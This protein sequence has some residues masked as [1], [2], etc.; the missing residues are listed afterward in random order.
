[1]KQEK[2]QSIYKYNLKKNKEKGSIT[3]YVLVACIFFTIVLGL[4]YVNLVYKSQGVEENLEQ[5]QDNYSKNE[6]EED[7]ANQDM[8]VTIQYKDPDI[9]NTWVKEITLVGS[10]ERK[11]GT[12]RNIA[13]YAFAEYDVDI[14]DIVW[15]ETADDEK[16]NLTKEVTIK[17]NGI[18]R[19][20]VKNDNE[21]ISYSD[22]LTVAN[23]DNIN[24]TPGY[25]EAT[26]IDPSDNITEFGSYNFGKWTSYNVYIE[27]F[28]GTDDESGH[29]SSKMTILKNSLT[30]P[31]WQNIDG[32][33]TLTEIG[34]YT[35]TVT[36]EDNLGNVSKSE[37]YYV[38]IDKNVPTLILKYHDENGGDYH[39]EWTNQDLYG[40]L[41]INTSESGKTVQ[42]YQYSQNGYTWNDMMDLSG[43]DFVAFINEML[44]NVHNITTDYYFEFNE[45]KTMMGSNNTNVNNSISEGYM[46]LDL[47]GYPW[48]N[49][50]LSISAKVS[51]EENHDYGFMEITESEES[52]NFDPNND[53]WIKVSGEQEISEYKLLS[54]GKKYYLHYGYSKDESTSVGTDSFS[55]QPLIVPAYFIYFA[56]YNKQGNNVTF[57]FTIESY[58]DDLYFRAIYD[59][60]T[61][62]YSKKSSSYPMRIDKTAPVV[63]TELIANGDKVDVKVNATDALSGIKQIYLSTENV[64][65]T[66]DSEW[67]SQTLSEFELN[68]LEMDTVYYLWV[69][70][71]AGNISEV[72]TFQTQANYRIDGDK[73]TTTLQQA[74]QV[75]STESISTIELLTGYDDKSEVVIDRNIVLDLK[76]FVLTRENEITINEGVTVR[77]TGKENS[78][79]TTN[80]SNTNTIIN[81]GNLMI[82]GNAV[83]ENFS[84]TESNRTI[85]NDGENAVI[86][87][88]EEAW[89]RGYYY[90]IYN[91]SGTVVID[92]GRV[93]STYSASSARGI[94]NETE[95]SKLYINNGEVQGYYGIYNNDVNSL[96]EITGGKVVGLNADGIHNIGIVNLYGGRVEGKSFG[97]YSESSNTVTI[98]RETDALTNTNPA[99]YGE[100][101]AVRMSD[102]T[103]Q[104]NLYNGTIGSTSKDTNYNGILNPRK[105]YMPYTYLST[106]DTYEIYNTSLTET[107]DNIEIT[108]SSNTEG[109]TNEDVIITVKYPYN[110]NNT[111]QYSFD[112]TTWIDTKDYLLGLN[113]EENKT[114]YIRILDEQGTVLEEKQ[115]EIKN[116]DQDD[117]IISIE[118]EQTS[119]TV[120]AEDETIDLNFS[121]AIED[122]GISG[123]SSTQYA[124]VR[125]G[126]QVIFEELNGTTLNKTNLGIGS[127][128]LYVRA[129]DNAGNEVEIVK[130][131]IISLD[132]SVE[133]TP[134]TEETTSTT[135]TNTNQT[136]TS[137]TN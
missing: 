46:V 83:I 39:G 93:E 85:F 5:I 109:F 34:T 44:G 90:G 4:T 24:P 57:N 26:E 113:I 59:E 98:G 15:T 20:Y 52:I 72:N 101:F 10:A 28:D 31:E 65:P 60:D 88:D 40:S 105:G 107:V 75:A 108:T 41:T 79:I 115:Y 63:T 122:V 92:N 45:D 22:R 120:F 12:V 7:N 29:K 62:D 133:T 74:I 97:I 17:E 37:P 25:I 84:T 104:F 119:Y 96:V 100:V 50:L 130:P 18:Y 89:V 13:F 110:I 27:K 117:P 99:V 35:I 54:G 19:F 128:H 71:Q 53:Y 134:E 86:N 87:I 131:Y 48:L 123:L 66:E 136:N 78:Q 56:N 70:D 124:W 36:T 102:E 2:S 47:T 64:P 125:D 51:S 114:V 77:I 118:P 76:G 16:Y 135:T 11:E 6:E 80:D 43:F 1:M 126:E 42:K 23:I 127:Y 106:Y 121:I 8:N 94:Y 67:I 112:G 14:N 38:L 33:V 9:T 82:Y 91:H 111:K 61:Q 58:A 68:N 32:P 49:I 116:I 69:Q 95:T 132:P 3:L 30:V 81:K 21:E 103:Y 137:T 55:F 73:V 129:I